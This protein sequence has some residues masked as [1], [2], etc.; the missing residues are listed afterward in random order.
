MIDLN[1]RILTMTTM[2]LSFSFM[3]TA[4]A[5]T[6]I[7]GGTTE[8]GSTTTPTC[9]MPPSCESL[10]YTKTADDC[11]NKVTLKCPLDE[12]K[13]YCADARQNGVCS[14][15]YSEIEKIIPYCT[16]DNARLVY[17]TKNPNCAKCQKCGAGSHLT[18]VSGCCPNN[19]TYNES[20][21]GCGGGKKYNYQDSN[22]CWTCSKCRSQYTLNADG[23]CVDPSVISGGECPAGYA[24][25]EEIISY[26]TESETVKMIEH[27][28][29]KGCY[30]CK[31]CS[32]G[33]YFN[34]KCSLGASSDGNGCTRCDSGWSC[35]LTSTD[36]RPVDGWCR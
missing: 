35:D 32:T 15:G 2:L 6:L 19:L 11:A 21:D 8:S 20:Q 16:G 23:L 28:S 5:Q 30:Q 25:Y 27:S 9:E 10:G 4:S 29:K 7:S 26:C 31:R 13:L 3:A 36:D 33:Y 17:D 24:K 14:D 34:N 1:N 22:G 12:S 18:Q